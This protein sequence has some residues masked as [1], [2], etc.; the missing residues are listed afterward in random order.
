MDII[1][2]IINALEKRFP[3]QEANLYEAL[4]YLRPKS[5][6]FLNWEKIKP[7][8]EYYSGLLPNEHICRADIEHLKVMGQKNKD[9]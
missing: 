6:N 1:D 2:A 9:T 7:L 8:W 4:D 5:D 3:E